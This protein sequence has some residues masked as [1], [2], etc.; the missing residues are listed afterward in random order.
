MRLAYDK[1]VEET[2]KRTGQVELDRSVA[3]KE[4]AEMQKLPK[5]ELT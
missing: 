2:L 4:E 1:T 3:E 5:E